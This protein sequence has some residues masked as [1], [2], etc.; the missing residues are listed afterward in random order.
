[1]DIIAELVR[2]RLTEELPPVKERDEMRQQQASHL[3]DLAQLRS[4]KAAE[5][6]GLVS[7]MSGQEKMLVSLKDENL[8]ELFGNG[9]LLLF[10]SLALL[11]CVLGAQTES[12]INW[13]LSFLCG[14]PI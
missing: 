6:K 3:V 10:V 13:I 9:A 4:R 2:A 11:Y 8:K 12:F 14:S 1:M 5:E 7:Q